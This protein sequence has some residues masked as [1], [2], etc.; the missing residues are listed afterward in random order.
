MDVIS[1][2]RIMNTQHSE[3][4]GSPSSTKAGKNAHLLKQV[5]RARE[6]RRITYEWFGVMLYFEVC[7]CFE[8][9]QLAQS[10]HLLSHV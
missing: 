4:I 2:R 5:T 7:S 3:H 8:I 10:G 6:P 9:G 1:K